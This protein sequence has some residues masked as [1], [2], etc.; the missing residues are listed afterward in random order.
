MICCN[1]DREPQDADGAAID[2]KGK[3]TVKKTESVN[4]NKQIPDAVELLLN[5][6]PPDI[7]DFAEVGSRSVIGDLV[8]GKNV[9]TTKFEDFV[10]DCI[11]KEFG[12]NNIANIF[13]FPKDDTDPHPSCMFHM[14]CVIEMTYSYDSLVWLFFVC[15]IYSLRGI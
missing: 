12:D 13:F 7:Y 15:N 5:A 4:C 8:I 9:M 2:N 14:F 10:F 11:C 3:G 6:S 1:C